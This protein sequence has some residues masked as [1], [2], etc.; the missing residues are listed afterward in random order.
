M[1]EDISFLE[2]LS[3][4]RNSALLS[5]YE[6]TFPISM[7]LAKQNNLNKDQAKTVTHESV[8][9]FHN[10]SLKPD[11]GLTCKLTTY[12]YSIVRNQ[13]RIVLAEKVNARKFIDT[14]EDFIEDIDEPHEYEEQEKQLGIALNEIDQRCRKI[15]KDYYFLKLSMETIAVENNFKNS[16]SAKSQKAKCIKE[17]KRIYFNS[18]NEE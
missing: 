13:M 14:Q 11:F 3:K 4:D 9:A 2:K 10:N 12:M 8:I 18:K 16:D 5:L 17:L 15:L 6:L 7:H 1:S